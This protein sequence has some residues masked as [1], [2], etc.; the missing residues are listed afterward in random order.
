MNIFN[1]GFSS[2]LRIFNTRACVSA[3]NIFWLS[4]FDDVSYFFRFWDICMD[5]VTVIEFLIELREFDIIVMAHLAL[6]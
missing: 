1:E 5:I 2:V 4:C 3:K 6:W